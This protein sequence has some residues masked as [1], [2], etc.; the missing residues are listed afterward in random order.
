LLVP[1]KRGVRALM[2]KHRLAR[3]GVAA[4][5]MCGIVAAT[6][7]PSNA[8][9]SSIDDKKAEAA[10][11]EA[12]IDASGQRL[13]QL[14]E[15]AHQAQIELDQAV[16]ARADVQRRIDNTQAKARHLQTLVA[17]RAVSIYQ[18]G[19][20][21]ALPDLDTTTVEQLGAQSKYTD[22]AARRDATL[23][24]ELQTA[25]ATLRAEKQQ[26]SELQ[27][28]ATAQR[29]TLAANRADADAAN[30]KQEQLL[31]QV[32]GEIAVLVQEDQQAKADAALAQSQAR[33]AQLTSQTAGVTTNS[34]SSNTT[35]T[36]TDSGSTSTGTSG[37]GSTSGGSTGGEPAV[38]P[39]AS[40]PVAYAY[41]QLGKPYCYGGVGPSCYDCSGLTMMAWAQAGV[42][43]PHGSIAQGDMFPQVPTA[44]MQPGDLVIEYADHSHVSIYIGNGM[45]I[46]APHTGDF[47]KIAPVFGDGWGFQYAVRPG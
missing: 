41:A 4:L 13:G 45:M 1:K 20:M 19:G 8:Q 5:L 29:D 39:G 2:S 38:S 44:D 18:D 11:L 23:I 27:A 25:K 46:T 35:S 15:L 6:A 26:Y 16:A 7:A 22:L 24:A 33:F 31:G 17:G 14:D 28:R 40:I 34:T 37:D 42:Y 32:Q 47:I 9:T 36:T 10:A 3:V 21:S 30:A 43:M 12:Q